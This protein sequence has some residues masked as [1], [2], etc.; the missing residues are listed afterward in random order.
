MQKL[1]FLIRAG[2]LIMIRR[3]I[4]TITLASLGLL[5]GA[6]C[7]DAD[8]QIVPVSGT[9]K[10][11]RVAPT[12]KAS[13]LDRYRDLNKLPA[14]TQSIVV[15]YQRSGSFL[16]RWNQSHG[17]FLPGWI[18]SLNAPLESDSILAQT[19][20]AWSLSEMARFTQDETSQIKAQQTILSLLSA[21][22]FDK[23][24]QQRM[25]VQHSVISNRVASAAYLMLA[26]Y[27]LPAPDQTRLAQAEELAQFIRSR[28][29]T[30]GSIQLNDAANE[31][32][33]D[34]PQ[35]SGVAMYAMAVSQRQRPAEWKSQAL[36]KILNIERGK[37]REDPHPGRAAWLIATTAELFRQSK[38][39]AFAQV[40]FEMCE[41]LLKQQYDQLDPRHLDWRGGYPSATE[42]K[43]LISR[44]SIDSA[45]A[46]WAVSQACQVMRLVSNPDLNRYEGLRRSVRSTN[47]FLLTL[48][49]SE[50]RL[51]H[52]V[53]TVRE[54]L[55]GGFF[56]SG[57]DGNLRIESAAWGLLSL[58]GYLESGIDLN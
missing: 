46:G 3:F 55:M 12:L 41:N 54:S 28:L 16:L 53:P 57:Q 26:I 6:S 56:G 34:Q 7:I 40:C 20:A 21:T 23:V 4:S 22:Q 30:D 31:D 51:M 58:Q 35:Y 17:R 29:K 25:P 11:E 42:G 50:D 8:E 38:E 45:V 9:A 48:Q 39:P 47:Q 36:G 15:A 44:P 1:S 32:S 52:F 37:F 24:T 18:P 19:I 49:C 13:G 43:T 14:S 33:V 27:A 5:I 10:A 2:R